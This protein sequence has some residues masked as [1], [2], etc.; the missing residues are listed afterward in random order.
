[1]K[2]PLSYVPALPAAIGIIAGILADRFG[3]GVAT[4]VV[5]GVL[6]VVLY[7]VRRHYPALCA[8]TVAVGALLAMSHK[9]PSPPAGLWGETHTFTAE[10]TETVEG[11][12]TTTYISLIRSIDTQECQPIPILVSV[13]SVAVPWPMGAMIGFTGALYQIEQKEEVPF[14]RDFAGPYLQ[15]GIMGRCYLNTPPE[16]LSPPTGMKAFTNEARLRIFN[17]IV[18]SPVNGPTASFLVASILGDRNYISTNEYSGYRDTG[19]AHILA[20]SGLHVGIIASMLAFLLMPLRLGRGGRYLSSTITAVAIWSYAVI[21]GLT[22]S[23]LR[24]AVMIT[25][26]IL[27]RLIGRGSNGYN[28]LSI[29][30]VVILCADPSS[31]FT[32]GFQLSVAAVA[33]IL[34]FGSLL[35]SGLRR[36]PILYLIAGMIVTS[37]SAMIGTGIISAYYFNTFPLLFIPANVLTG[38]LFPLILGGGIILSVF[39]AMGIKLSL[40]G[41][42]VDLLHSLMQEGIDVLGSM[43]EAVMHQVFFSAAVIVPYAMAVIMLA[44]A[45]HYRRRVLWIVTGVLTIATFITARVTTPALPSA[46]MYIPS[47]LTPTTIIMRAGD[48]A[49]LYTPA[50]SQIENVLAQ[51][52]ARYSRFLLSRG[53]GDSF[54]AVTDTLDHTTFGIRGQMIS[55]ANRTIAIVGQ[56]IPERSDAGKHVDY[57]LICPDFRGK[58]EDIAARLRPDTI[59]LG[60]DLHPARRK[61]LIR[62]CGD[63]IPYLN[64]RVDAMSEVW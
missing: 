21:V 32:P 17:A 45:L 9:T 5:A 8:L 35:P 37:V 55:A 52:N 44:F 59:L 15:R 19:V 1:M 29:S 64:L 43:D 49:W 16:E 20:L 38:I 61:S 18:D 7:V 34:M 14:E 58:I 31:L 39:T 48:R 6:F 22:P 3:I 27:A 28:S 56:Y 36:H 2:A 10:V 57:A 33:T 13:N 11:S 41:Y 46:E 40:L 12:T 24:A 30:V 50:S 60:T 63:S 53:C 51:A 4:A 62:Q 25:V 47:S 54:V 23:I 26:F 42:A